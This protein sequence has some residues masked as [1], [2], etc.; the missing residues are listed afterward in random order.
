MINDILA[1]WTP[2]PLELIIICFISFVIFV[3]PV[4]LVIFIVVYLVQN[5]KEKQKLRMEVEKLAEEV[6][7]L[8][9]E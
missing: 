1:F 8:K 9:K 4:A 5:N 3:I 7:E 6:N 2:G